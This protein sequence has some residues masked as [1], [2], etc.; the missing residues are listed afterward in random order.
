MKWLTLILVSNKLKFWIIVKDFYVYIIR[1][2][3]AKINT[4]L[5]GNLVRVHLMLKKFGVQTTKL[6]IILKLFQ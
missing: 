5:I 2:D 4:Y 1:K 3:R 6:L